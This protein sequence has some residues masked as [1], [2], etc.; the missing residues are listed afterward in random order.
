[1][2][3]E[4]RCL[5]SNNDRVRLTWEHKMSYSLVHIR[6]DMIMTCYKLGFADSDKSSQCNYLLRVSSSSF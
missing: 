2:S 4:V 5:Q 3:S 6:L 1:M